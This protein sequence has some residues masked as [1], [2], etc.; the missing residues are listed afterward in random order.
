MLKISVRRILSLALILSLL[1]PDAARAIPSFSRLETRSAAYG[2]QAH[3]P[4]EA[5]SG[6]A[7]FM[8]HALTSMGFRVRHAILDAEGRAPKPT[9]A[10]ILEST[11]WM[12]QQVATLTKDN[13]EERRELLEKALGREIELTK[14]IELRMREGGSPYPAL[15]TA[16]TVLLG[17]ADNVHMSMLALPMTDLNE[18]KK[19]FGLDGFADLFKYRLY[20][21]IQDYARANGKSIDLGYVAGRLI[22][23]NVD[24]AQDAFWLEA[25]LRQT[26]RQLTDRQEVSA[27]LNGMQFYVSH[28][29]LYLNPNEPERPLTFDEEAEKIFGPDHLNP[30][31]SMT[32]VQNPLLEVDTS[33]WNPTLFSLVESLESE[34]NDRERRQNRAQWAHDAYVAK[35]EYE[36][37]PSA[38][39]QAASEKVELLLWDGL[40]RLTE[41]VALMRQIPGEDVRT[42]LLETIDPENPHAGKGMLIVFPDSHMQAAKSAIEKMHDEDPTREILDSFYQAIET[43]RRDTLPVFSADGKLPRPTHQI[44]NFDNEKDTAYKL[45]LAFEQAKFDFNLT[46]FK[47]EYRTYRAAFLSALIDA[48]KDPRLNTL[49]S[50]HWIEEVLDA[51]QRGLWDDAHQRLKNL[52]NPEMKEDN[53]YFSRAVETISRYVPGQFLAKRLIGDEL[54]IALKVLTLTG[55]RYRLGFAE[56]NKGSSYFYKYAPDPADSDYHRIL[57]AFQSALQRSY[58]YVPLRVIHFL[59]SEWTLRLYMGSLNR[60]IRHKDV[61][62]NSFRERVKVPTRK[63]IGRFP[64]YTHTYLD[65]DFPDITH[66]RTVAHDETHNEWYEKRQGRWELLQG[67]EIPSPET[68]AQFKPTPEIQLSAARTWLR[69]LVT[70]S[71]VAHEFN[72]LDLMNAHQK[73][74]DKKI[75]EVWALED[76]GPITGLLILAYGLTQLIDRMILPSMI[77]SGT[78]QLASMLPERLSVLLPRVTLFFDS[79]GLSMAA[80]AGLLILLGSIGRFADSSSTLAPQEVEKQEEIKRPPMEILFALFTVQ[81]ILD[82]FLHRTPSHPAAEQLAGMVGNSSLG[83]VVFILGIATVGFA[84]YRMTFYDEIDIL[85]KRMEHHLN[86]LPYGASELEENSHYRKIKSDVLTPWIDEQIRESG[87][88]GLAQALEALKHKKKSWKLLASRSRWQTADDMQKQIQQVL[89]PQTKRRANDTLFIQLP[90]GLEANVHPISRNGEDMLFLQ[91]GHTKSAYEGKELFG[92]KQ[93][94][95]LQLP[96]L[97]EHEGTAFIRPYESAQGMWDEYTYISFPEFVRQHLL[98]INTKLT[99]DPF[100]KTMAY[101][102]YTQQ[103]LEG[104]V[105]LLDNM[106]L[107]SEYESYLN[108]PPFQKALENRLQDYAPMEKNPYAAVK[109]RALVFF[110]VLVAGV[111]L[112]RILSPVSDTDFSLSK[113]LRRAV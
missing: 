94:I 101:N 51:D 44:P 17:K 103:R 109:S 76:L 104:L 23:I 27:R 56:L 79:E 28:I 52:L 86:K 73:K 41:R 20:T 29:N 57:R 33:K 62:P 8:Q 25:M 92:T 60:I 75:M 47:K 108:N 67:K 15:E 68:V 34:K 110:R 24:P 58:R 100:Y 31:E 9:L 38:G 54:L 61:A 48:H 91:I 30:S 32:V 14:A 85:L 19:E 89:M 59:S 63:G 13:F 80:I 93:P 37:N 7:V 16:E 96:I 70:P 21:N 111:G 78:D 10:G 39:R 49:I 74:D 112:S 88:S 77:P 64:T 106:A 55:I 97:I 66:T 45:L 105:A 113:H 84:L 65:K 82:L 102:I 83:M 3:F 71:E 22:L 40:Q 11:N 2:V 18:F 1:T 6:V 90:N 43:G 42:R 72:R 53:P 98:I 99:D 26:M 12:D 46:G 35:R 50:L 69:R 5:F 36:H 4:T 81:P 87:M 107:R 95:R